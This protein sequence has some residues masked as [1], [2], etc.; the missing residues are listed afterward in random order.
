MKIK[1][2][3][4]PITNK[5]KPPIKIKQILSSQSKYSFDPFCQIISNTSPLWRMGDMIW[6][7]WAS[8]YDLEEFEGWK[9]NKMFRREKPSNQTLVLLC[10]FVSGWIDCFYA[11]RTLPYCVQYY[12]Y[13][14]FVGTHT[15]S[16]IQ[17]RSYC[18]WTNEPGVVLY[19]S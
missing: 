17:S 3:K 16:P 9:Q 13:I 14:E 12:R 15:N 4:Q 6:Q 1:Q 10:A 7:R 11:I 19:R 18:Y 5:I 8:P 2:N